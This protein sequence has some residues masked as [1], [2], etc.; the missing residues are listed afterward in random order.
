MPLRL[1]NGTVHFDRVS[2]G[3]GPSRTVLHSVSFTLAGG[4]T[5]ALVG[6]TGSGKSTILRLLLRFYD[7]TSGAVLIDG[8]NIAKVAGARLYYRPR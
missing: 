8:Q 5:M 6:A 2:F 1:G 4:K 7:P 3:Y